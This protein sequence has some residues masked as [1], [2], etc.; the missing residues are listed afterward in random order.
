[1]SNIMDHYTSLR[2]R[3]HIAS[4]GPGF[5]GRNP[6]YYWLGRGAEIHLGRNVH[7]ERKVNMSLADNARIYVGDD[8]YIGQGCLFATMKEI[9]IGQGCAISWYV[10][11]MDT[12]SH[13][14]GIKGEELKM[15]VEPI[16]I[17]NHVWIGCRAS[18]IRGVTVGDGAI[19]ANNAN[20]TRD[21]P[22]GTMVGGNP[23][24]VIKENVDWL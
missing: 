15:Q 5:R 3:R 17:G 8:T 13:Q 14:L 23:A 4:C 19:I 12:S 21:V 16:R 20:V 2:C 18:I 7:I 11:F 9:S 1:M 6:G 24:R 22:P 10:C